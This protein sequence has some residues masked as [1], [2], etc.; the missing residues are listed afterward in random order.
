MWLATLANLR[1]NRR[2]CGGRLSKCLVLSNGTNGLWS[3]STRN[4]R[5]RMYILNFSHAQVVA[6]A[7]FS[8][9]A[10][11]FSVSESNLEAYATGLQL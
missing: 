1:R 8:I 11:L 7:S 3:V 6:R 9:C 5:P 2:T 10:Y 4:D